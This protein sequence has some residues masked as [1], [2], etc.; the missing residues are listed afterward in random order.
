M[1]LFK[2]FLK[3]LLIIGA[4]TQT[5]RAWS[6][7]MVR[8]GQVHGCYIRPPFAGGLPFAFVRI[9]RVWRQAPTEISAGEVRA[10]GFSDRRSFLRVLTDAGGGR[11]P[12]RL[13]AVEFAVLWCALPGR[14]VSAARMRIA[15]TGVR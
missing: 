7:A 8:A 3:P 11:L 14:R 10:E 13:F 2:P 12:R 4:K 6:R 15:I 5:R 1:L 9:G